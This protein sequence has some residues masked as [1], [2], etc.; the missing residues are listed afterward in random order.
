[1]NKP[2]LRTAP[3]KRKRKRFSG[4]DERELMAL[5]AQMDLASYEQLKQLHEYVRGAIFFH[6][7]LNGL[8]VMWR[9]TGNH[10]DTRGKAAKK[11]L[12]DL[13]RDMR[14]YYTREDMEP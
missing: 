12:G 14:A 9:L 1:M 7:Y 13:R 3:K 5:L 6:G 10:Y 11:V 2:T 4:L 8:S